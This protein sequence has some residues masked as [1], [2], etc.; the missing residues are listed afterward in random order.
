MYRECR[1][2][3]I[4]DARTSRL[5]TMYKKTKHRSWLIRDQLAPKLTCHSSKSRAGGSASPMREQAACERRIEKP[6]YW[7]SLIGEHLPPR[8]TCRSIRAGGS[9]SPMREQAACERCIKKA[10]VPEFAD[11]ESTPTKSEHA[12]C[13]TGKTPW[14]LPST[15]SLNY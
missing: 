10:K 3:C 8:Q 9:A 7:S 1:W 14:C 11:L 6:K 12:F 4:R 13:P 5:R 2:E 15:I